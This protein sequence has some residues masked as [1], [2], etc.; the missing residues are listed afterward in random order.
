MKG[1]ARSTGDMEHSLTRGMLFALVLVAPFWL[2][3]AT[4]MVVLRP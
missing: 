3:M 1:S 4:L 2:G